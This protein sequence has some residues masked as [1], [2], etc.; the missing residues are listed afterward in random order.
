[1][2]VGD[3]RFRGS[4]LLLCFWDKFAFAISHLLKTVEKQPLPPQLRRQLSGLVWALAHM[5]FWNY[6]GGLHVNGNPGL[7]VEGLIA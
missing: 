4:A 2:G 7:P 6:W 3:E 5:V 1:M